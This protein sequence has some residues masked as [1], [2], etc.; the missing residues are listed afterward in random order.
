MFTNIFYTMNSFFS[1]KD[2]NMKGTITI[3]SD[4]EDRKIIMKNDD[5]TCEVEI[6]HNGIYKGYIEI[7]NSSG[8]YKV[9]L[10]EKIKDL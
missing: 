7:L 9:K 4:D 6:K 1:S 8:K 5:R 10:L 2:N 3:S